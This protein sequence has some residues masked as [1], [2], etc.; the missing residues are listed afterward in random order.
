MLRA[1]QT[2]EIINKHLSKDVIL[3]YRLRSVD[4]VTLEGRFISDISQEEWT[5][6][7][8]APTFFYAESTENVYLRIK[9]FF[10]EQFSREYF[11]NLKYTLYQ[12]FRIQAIQFW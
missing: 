11:H 5:L 2:T 6:Y 9:S 3:D 1:I 10:D 4:Y 8:S 12:V 7:N